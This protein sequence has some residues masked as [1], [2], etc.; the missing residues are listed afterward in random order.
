MGSDSD[1]EP[2]IRREPPDVDVRGIRGRVCFMILPGDASR[3][4]GAVF[5]LRE[6]DAALAV[7]ELPQD[8]PRRRDLRGIRF[9]SGGKV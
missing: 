1:E 7:L 3:I 4:W 8:S 9:S 6:G 2:A 5:T